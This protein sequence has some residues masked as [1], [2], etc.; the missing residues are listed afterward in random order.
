MK[1]SV[2][3][4]KVVIMIAVSSLSITG[5]K[6]DESK[7]NNDHRSGQDQSSAQVLFNDVLHQMDKVYNESSQSGFKVGNTKSLSECVSVSITPEGT[8]IWPKTVVLDYGSSNCL[9]TDG[10]NRRGK[11]TGFFSGPYREEGAVITITLQDYF[12]NDVFVEG[13]ER[14]TNQGRNNAQYGRN[15]VYKVEVVAARFTNDEGSATWNSTSTHEWIEGE[16]TEGLEWQDDVYMVDG[17]AYGTDIKG[18]SYSG[19][20]T[21]AM[22]CALDCQWIQSGSVEITSDENITFSVDYGSGNCDNK[23]TINYKGLIIPF[24]MR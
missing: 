14:I 13:T 1:S 8:D 18:K 22:R 20:T 3:L 10:K 5:C 2:I 15:L 7:N 6:K 24:S 16:S 19:K 4:R 12:E 23:A 21:K 9:C 17:I 11:I